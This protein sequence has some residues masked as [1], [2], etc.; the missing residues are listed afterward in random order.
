MLI[1]CACSLITVD[2]CAGE[3]PDPPLALL[4]ECRADPDATRTVVGTVDAVAAF[5][6]DH[7]AAAVVARLDIPRTISG[8]SCH[9]VATVSSKRP[10]T[11]CP[12][13]R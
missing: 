2:E 4:K 13:L 11:R 9:V 1:Q 8:R 6:A 12:H 7:L 5:T 10:T 3:M